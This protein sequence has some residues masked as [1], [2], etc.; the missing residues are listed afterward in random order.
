M[1]YDRDWKTEAEA[2]AYVA[3]LEA[4]GLFKR[5]YDDAAETYHII[6]FGAIWRVVVVVI[7]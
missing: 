4:A 2:K 3:G 7:N 5:G 6:Q 1:Q